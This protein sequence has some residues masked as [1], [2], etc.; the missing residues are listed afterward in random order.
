MQGCSGK[1][2]TGPERSGRLQNEQGHESRQGAPDPSGAAHYGNVVHCSVNPRVHED[3]RASF[4]FFAAQ[5]T[6][7]P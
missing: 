1:A 4:F 7:A 6:P 3:F 2:H 5:L